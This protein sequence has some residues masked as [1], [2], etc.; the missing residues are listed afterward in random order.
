MIHLFVARDV[1]SF[2]NTFS[3]SSRFFAFRQGYCANYRQGQLFSCDFPLFFT[4][5]I[6]STFEGMEQLIARFIWMMSDNIYGG[7]HL[8]LKLFHSNFDKFS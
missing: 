6:T 5:T 1:A 4:S 8:G 7:R 3:R 2:F